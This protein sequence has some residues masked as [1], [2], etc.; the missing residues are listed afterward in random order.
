VASSRETE[1]LGTIEVDV[2]IT[3]LSLLWA[4]VLGTVILG[5]GFA[6]AIFLFVGLIP[7]EIS[8]LGAGSLAQSTFGLSLAVGA[9][10]IVVFATG[11]RRHG[12]PVPTGSRVQQ[13]ALA[14]T[15]P[16]AWGKLIREEIHLRDPRLE[17]ASPTRDVG[18][19]SSDSAAN[20]TSDGLVVTGT[21]PEWWDPGTYEV[22]VGPGDANSLRAKLTNEA[23]ESPST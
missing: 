8:D 3:P 15:V 7:V 20:P 16:P 23:A 12:R 18:A 5:T 22:H 14:V 10:F 6:G 13:N 1:D 4:S 2:R 17:V 9:L 19:E 11:Y 21:A